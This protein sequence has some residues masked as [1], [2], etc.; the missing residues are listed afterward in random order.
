MDG[1]DW[2]DLVRF[3]AVLIAAILVG[4]KLK[5]KVLQDY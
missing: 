3:V 5:Q 1:F 4:N 2:F